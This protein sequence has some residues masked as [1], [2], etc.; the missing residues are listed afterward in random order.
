M[1]LSKKASF[2]AKP[3][4]YHAKDLTVAVIGSGHVGIPYACVCA[5]ESI[6]R[7]WLVDND[8]STLQ[9]LIKGVIPF[10]EP[11]LQEIYDQFFMK[12]IF[13]AD[14]LVE[15]VSKSDVVIVTVGTPLNASKE[16]NI[17]NLVDACTKVAQAAKS[18]TLILLM[19]TVP[20]G[21]T[22]SLI[23]PCFTKASLPIEREIGLAYCPE[24]MLEG[25][26]IESIKKF[27][28][29][30]GAV[31][32]RSK[33]AAIRFFELLS[34]KTEVLSGPEEAEV[35]KLICNAY[36]MVNIALANELA[37][38]CEKLGVDAHKVFKAAN[39]SPI[40]N[41]M[42]P[43]MMGGSCLTK[44]PHFLLTSAS[45]VGFTPKI[46]SEA[47]N[48]I[49]SLPQ[50]VSGLFVDAMKEA[51]K[52]VHNSKVAILGLAYK[53]STSDTRDSPVIP[54]IKILREIGVGEIIA[55]DPF[56]GKDKVSE[57]SLDVADSL[58]DA[59][60]SADCVILGTEHTE[61]KCVND[62][63]VLSQ[64][65]EKPVILDCKGILNEKL[66]DLAVQKGIGAVK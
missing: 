6:G 20:V 10:Y 27:V 50:H 28:K 45:K 63:K 61:F 57:L 19:S 66:S 15:A 24:R 52:D 46:L 16:P 17:Q 34:I 58:T 55:Y 43:G 54:L 13:V 30:I 32:E 37:I 65:R 9:S 53:G 14:E 56:V 64:M 44:D 62:P 12:S 5:T 8:D 36:R 25:M 59:I 60:H 42:R 35:A 40:V 51:G 1:P 18:G 23:I 47:K 2:L 29:L 33:R 22:R 3:E 31:G 39:T 49:N 38:L 21:T 11:N 7:V 4:A 41:L 26:A 48:V